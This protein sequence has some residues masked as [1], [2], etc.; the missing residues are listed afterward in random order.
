MT[1]LPVYIINLR[2]RPDRLHK[3]I[4]QFPAGT[5]PI[6]IDAVDG[7]TLE[8]VPKKFTKGEYACFLSHLKTLER[9][10]RDPVNAY[11]LVLEDDAVVD[12]PNIQTFLRTMPRRIG[13]V[14]LGCNGYPPP[15]QI[16]DIAPGI[17]AFD[18]YDLYGA[19]ALLYSRQGARDCLRHV[20]MFGITDPFD[21]WLTRSRATTVYIAKPSLASVRSLRD[22]DTQSTR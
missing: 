10:A 3:C 5:N 17:V 13:V 9:I 22:T 11:A 21:V 19:H 7:Y 12:L 18:K 14:S 2:R 4:V 1:N 6:V 16:I 8:N 15:A 20:S